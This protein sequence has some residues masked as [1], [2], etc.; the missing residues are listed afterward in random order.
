MAKG[1]RTKSVGRVPQQLAGPN[2][3]E[4]LAHLFDAPNS[5]VVDDDGDGIHI[6]VVAGQRS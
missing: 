4:D 2:N 1:K 6:C 5:G 3:I